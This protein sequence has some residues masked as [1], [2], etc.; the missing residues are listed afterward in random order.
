E[1]RGNGRLIL[2]DPRSG[3]T[4]TL[5]RGLIFAN[6]VTLCPDEKSLLFAE[7]WACRISR[8]WFEGPKR[9]RT[10]IFMD[11][12]PGYP[13]NVNRG[14]NGTYW[15]ALLGMRTKT[16]DLAMRMPGFRRRMA[17]RIA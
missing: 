13:D 7:T 14:S 15:V 1:G 4:R 8:F 3:T 9:G 16:F 17:R 2:H 5:L 6:G 10:E 11:D 12:L